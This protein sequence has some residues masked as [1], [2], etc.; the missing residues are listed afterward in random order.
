MTIVDE[1]EEVRDRLRYLAEERR[2]VGSR[3]RRGARAMRALVRRLDFII[4][5]LND[6]AQRG[7]AREAAQRGEAYPGARDAAQDRLAEYMLLWF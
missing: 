1:V 3:R 6:A 2:N 5:E 7:A 4:Q